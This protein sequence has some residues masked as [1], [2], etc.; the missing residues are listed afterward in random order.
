VGVAVSGAA[1]ASRLSADV[2]LSQSGVSSL[3]L[4]LSGARRTMLAIRRGIGFSLAY[5]VIGISC[6]AL[7]ILGPLGAAILMP[8]SS[9]TVVTNAYRSRTFD[10]SKG[11]LHINDAEEVA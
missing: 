9:L 6:A 5:N 3:V 8:L 4:L 11:R 7:G 2:F 1:E 10:Q